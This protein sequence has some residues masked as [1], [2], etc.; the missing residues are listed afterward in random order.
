MSKQQEEEQYEEYIKKKNLSAIDMYI[1]EIEK[2][3]RENNLLL[4]KIEY[5]IEKYK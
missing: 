1:K 2:K 3:I 4:K 5:L